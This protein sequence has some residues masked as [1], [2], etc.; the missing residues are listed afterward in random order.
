MILTCPSCATRYQADDARFAP[1]GRNVRCAKCGEVWYQ[2]AAAAVIEPEPE[3]VVAAQPAA[4]SF[5]SHAEAPAELKSP[6]IEREP[7]PAVTPGVFPEPKMR[8][9]GRKIGRI[10]GRAAG[11]AAL[12]LTIAAV[13]WSVLEFR[14]TIANV[15]PQSAS[16]YAAIGMPVNASQMALSDITY[17]Q[18]FE[19]GQPVLSVKGKVVNLSDRELPVPELQVVLMDEARRVLYQWTFDAGIPSLKPGEESSF[20]TR[21]SSPPEEARNLNIRF[22]DA[23]K[24][25]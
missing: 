6:R 14:Q 11:W 10:V 4:E 23:G 17:L 18:E 2:V 5:A 20:V 1:P 21:L 7:S 9:T 3:P 8:Q 15:W 22:A 13:G 19:D 12:L 25:K 16:L 24:G